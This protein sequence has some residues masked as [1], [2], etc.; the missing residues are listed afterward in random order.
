MKY[1]RNLKLFIVYKVT[2]QV[3]ESKISRY[4]KQYEIFQMEQNINSYSMYTRFTDIVNT[5]EV[6]GKTFSK[7]ENVKKIIRHLLK[8]WRSKRTAIEEEKYLNYLSIDDLISSL[9][10][11]EEDL[12]VEKMIKTR[13]KEHYS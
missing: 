8:E 5:L 7:S 2:N 6:L 9:I 12:A 3:K 1:G 4:T 11:Y 13:K 10:P